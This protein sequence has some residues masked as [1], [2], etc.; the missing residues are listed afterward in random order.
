K[1]LR[2]LEREL[3][4]SEATFYRYKHSDD[5]GKPETSF[6]IC[7]YWFIEALARLGLVDE[8]RQNFEKLLSFRNHLGL[9][10]EHVNPVD[11][12][13]WGNFPQTYSHVGLLN[14]AFQISRTLNK[15]N[16]LTP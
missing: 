2:G 9:L 8:A 16:F 10:S 5:F 1:H 11:G 7:S 14:A 6:V 13:Q 15:P 3:K 12:S 4:Q